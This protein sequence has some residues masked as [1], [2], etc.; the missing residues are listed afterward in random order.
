MGPL[1]LK[2]IMVAHVILS[3]LGTASKFQCYAKRSRFSHM[4][5][6]NSWLVLHKVL[7]TDISLQDK[8][9]GLC[10]SCGTEVQ[11]T[12]NLFRQGYMFGTWFASEPRQNQ[13]NWIK[14]HFRCIKRLI[15]FVHIIYFIFNKETKWMEWSW[16]RYRGVLLINTQTCIA[17]HGKKWCLIGRRY[18]NNEPCGVRYPV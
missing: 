8:K 6:W 3:I 1:V 13:Y 9:N 5:I 14:F 16:Q 17:C 7:S 15:L 4:E 2:P 10:V 18:S 12:K 11:F